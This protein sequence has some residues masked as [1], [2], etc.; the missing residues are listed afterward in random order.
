MKEQPVVS[1]VI[2]TFNRACLVKRAIDSVLSQTFEDYE[3]IV[4]DDFSTDH[5]PQ[6]VTELNDA[7][8]NYVRHPQNMG[9]AA[10]RNTGIVLAKGHFIAFLDSDDTWVANKLEVQLKAI[11]HYQA[12]SHIVAY[13]QRV[14]EHSADQKT[15]PE[16]GKEATLPL[17]EYLFCE[18][19][20]MQTS[21]LVLSTQL[22]NTIKFRPSLKKH[23]D[24]DFCLR[25]EAAG[26]D[27]VFI[28]QPLSIWNNE[29]RTDQVS[30]IADYRL[31]IDWINDWGSAI[32]SRAK[33]GFLYIEVLPKL[34]RLKEN[35]ILAQRI[36]LSSFFHG[37]IPF[38][39]LKDLTD[40]NFGYS[41]N[42]HQFKKRLKRLKDKLM[43]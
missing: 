3:I 33:S 29:P 13:S 7:R 4:V 6:V 5:T 10:S 41:H 27:F 42:L 24:W 36:L 9:G 12:S 31:S 32:S 37:L 23:Q 1:V 17:A 22:A 39:K 25:L 2:P 35:K 28:N 34:L 11:E 8:I 26:A 30:R 40:V 20:D 15:I 14:F 43:A 16:R 19:G 21:T 38:E 18:Q